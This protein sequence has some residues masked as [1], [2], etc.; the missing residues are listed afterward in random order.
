MQLLKEQPVAHSCR[1]KRLTV[2]FARPARSLVAV[3]RW[4]K[5]FNQ[6]VLSCVT[7]DRVVTAAA[8]DLLQHEIFACLAQRA[9]IQHNSRGSRANSDE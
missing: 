5:D 8:K 9:E 6:E 7:S 2:T 4:L 1:A 3:Q